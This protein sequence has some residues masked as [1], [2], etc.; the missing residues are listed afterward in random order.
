MLNL[1]KTNRI[2]TQLLRKTSLV[3]LF[4]LVQLLFVGSVFAQTQL[5]LTSFSV[6]PPTAFL[7][8]KP[9]SQATHTITLENTSRETLFIQ[10]S[11]VDFSPDGKTG[12]PVLESQTTFPYL[13]FP[14]GRTVK[15]G[16]DLTKIKPGEKAQLTLRI[17]VPPLE[18]EKEWP[19]TILFTARPNPEEASPTRTNTTVLPSIGSNL[20]VLVSHE[21]QPVADLELLEAGVP[22]FADSLRPLTLKPVVKNTRFAATVA[23]GTAELKNWWGKTIATHD[24]Y[25]EIILGYSSRKMTGIAPAANLPQDKA[26]EKIPLTLKPSFLMGVYQVTYTVH[27]PTGIK[28]LPVKNPVIALPF[29]LIATL[30]MVAGVSF[31]LWYMQRKNK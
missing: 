9:G 15:N 31:G 16:W 2:T 3:V 24:I 12:N 11:M 1:N 19:V 29:S 23:S 30:L 22:Q 5:D 4:Q 25:P 21:E 6:S 18:K 17:A 13:T 26:P 27:T 14:D 8:V 20:I 7:L 10:P 28:Q